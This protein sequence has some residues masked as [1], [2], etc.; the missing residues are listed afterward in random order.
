VVVVVAAAG[1]NAV[2]LINL[3][4]AFFFVHHAAYLT[5]PHVELIMAYLVAIA[6]ILVMG[7]ASSAS[8]LG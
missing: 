3:L 6:A 8:T 5:N 7:P 4:T 2:A 1:G